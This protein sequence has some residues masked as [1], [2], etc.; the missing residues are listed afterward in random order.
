MKKKLWI[1]GHGSF[2]KLNS[3]VHSYD[4]ETGE[5]GSTVDVGLMPI[6]I[7]SD[8]ESPFLY[9]LCHGN[10]SLYQIDKRT[11][12][13]IASL[14]VGENPNAINGNDEQL[15]VT[16]LDGDSV[17]IINRSSFEIVNEL[18]VPPGPYAII[19]EES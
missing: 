16:N 9:A 11:D 17:S 13:V 2:G 10:H 12:E 1:G 8:D 6:A 3:Q 18:K 5:P 14:E 7:Y 19:L 15:F 4:L